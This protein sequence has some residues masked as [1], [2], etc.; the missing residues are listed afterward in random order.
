MDDY[1]RTYVMTV[2]FSPA[3]MTSAIPDFLLMWMCP[4][5]GDTK[6]AMPKVA[7]NEI[8]YCQCGREW[9]FDF[10]DV[11]DLPTEAV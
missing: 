1:K 3:S 5:C 11:G 7:A 6:I 10:S 8:I 9:E 2:S 4:G